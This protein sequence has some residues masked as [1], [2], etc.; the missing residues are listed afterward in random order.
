MA[1]PKDIV[2][3]G[4][5]AGAIEALTKLVG[6]LPPD[7]HAAVFVVVHT[8]PVG[9]SMLPAILSRG[10]TLTAQIPKDGDPIECDRIYV[11][12]KDCHLLIEGGRIKLSSGPKESGHRPAID[13]LFRSAARA[14]GQR[15]VGIVLSGTLDDGSAGLRLIR[16]H[17]GTAIVQD[18][19]EA[20]FPQMPLNA[21]D[22]AHP[23]HVAPIVEIAQL[24]ASHTA[25]K[26]KGG[27][28]AEAMTEALNPNGGQTPIGADD[29]AGHPTGIAC[30]ECHG[31][32][33]AAE[34]DESPEFR[35][36]V[37]HAYSSEGFLEAHAESVEA[38]LWAGVRALEEQA[39]LTR[40]LSG[41]ADRRGDRLS[42]ARLQERS[43]ASNQQAR[44]IE[45][46]LLTRAAKPA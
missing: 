33:W 15:V 25:P 45:A 3:I 12:P 4:G 36:R 42:A 2:V 21:I 41:K 17:G 13:P 28:Q 43:D 11:A 5:S 20:L 10:S 29:I 22:A 34:D 39:S 7:L 23:Q 16:R 35:C 1:E 31:V 30:P 19:R 46:M 37:G 27:E 8:F 40:H 44:M 14:F 24:I 6:R 26:R 38:A 9:D 18:P 32:M